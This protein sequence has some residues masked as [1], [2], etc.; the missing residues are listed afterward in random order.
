MADII[1]YMSP[2][3]CS[4]VTMTALEKIGAP[5]EDRLIFTGSNTQKSPGYLAVNR[6]GKIPAL[7]VDGRVLTENAAILAYLDQLHPEAALL[8]HSGGDALADAQGLSDMMW[9]SSTLHIEVRQNRAP[10]RLT[11][12]DP[13]GV[14]ADGVAKFADNCRYISSRVDAG[15]WW[16]GADW[17]ILDTY[18]YWCYST[19]KLGGFPLEDFPQLLAHAERVRAEPS[20]QKALARERAAVEREGLPIDPASL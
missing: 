18:I 10:Q 1:L 20:F 5:Y 14:R 13:A 8:P 11:T 16:Y 6:K 2:G 12:G 4:R 19:A 3:A 17:S 7:S 9:C 15:R